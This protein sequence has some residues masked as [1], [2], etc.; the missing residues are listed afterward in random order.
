MN[1]SNCCAR[2][3][4]TIFRLTQEKA[5]F[6]WEERTRNQQEDNALEDWL[7]AEKWVKE[8]FPWLSG[9]KFIGIYHI[10]R[11]EKF[12]PDILSC[13]MCGLIAEEDGQEVALGFQRCVCCGEMLEVLEAPTLAPQN[14]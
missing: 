5:Y 7:A 12:F 1:L 13:P 14:P 3:Q 11:R 2:E 6:L 10:V 8:S 4:Q 9:E